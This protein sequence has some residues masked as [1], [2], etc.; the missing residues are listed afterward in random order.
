MRILITALPAI[1]HLRPLVAVGQA[2]AQLGHSVAVCV[3]ETA[4]A[5]VESYGL[6]HLAAGHDTIAEHLAEDA[7]F[8]HLPPDHGERVRHGLLTEGY[9]GAPA[10]HAARDIKAHAER[11]QPDVIVRD[12]CEFGGY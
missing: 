3:P 1:G 9:P 6:N 2:A 8:D 12:T 4:K 7:R 10:R 11:W 5:R